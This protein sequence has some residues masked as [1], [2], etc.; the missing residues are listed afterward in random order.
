MR[1]EITKS[2]WE[3][4]YFICANDRI[5]NN[6]ISEFLSMNEKKYIKLLE[7]YGA[8]YQLDNGVYYFPTYQKAE[9]FLNS[10]EL[11]P[12]IMMKELVE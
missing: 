5:G 11:L 2:T 4:G 3:F 12:Y 10:D 8:K 9:E 7:K 6:S 1:I